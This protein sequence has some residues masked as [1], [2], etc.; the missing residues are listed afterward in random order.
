MELDRQTHTRWQPILTL[1]PPQQLSS[2]A[3]TLV[4]YSATRPMLSDEHDKLFRVCMLVERVKC[5]GYTSTQRYC[6]KSQGQACFLMLH[7]YDF[8]ELISLFVFVARTLKL[9]WL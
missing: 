7:R 9:K 1:T 4:C 3:L 6:D 5:V 2:L 8:I